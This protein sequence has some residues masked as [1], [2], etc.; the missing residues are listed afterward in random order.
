MGRI[1]IDK[2]VKRDLDTTKKKVNL[3]GKVLKE[4][5]NLHAIIMERL[6]T[7]KTNVG[8]ME[9]KSSMES[10][11][12]AINMVTKLTNARRNLNLKVNVTNAEGMVTRH[13]NVDLNHSI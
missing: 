3:P 4:I 8:A 1:F 13:Q 7:H 6:V 12:S 9:K 5:R 11:T 10:V 2:K